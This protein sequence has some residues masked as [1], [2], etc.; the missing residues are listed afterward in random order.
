M[1]DSTT[2]TTK[3][4][5]E[6]LS[7]LQQMTSQILDSVKQALENLG[8]P[9]ILQNN[10]HHFGT[11]FQ[12][13]DA[14][15]HA[16]PNGPDS[17]LPNTALIVAAALHDIGKP[18]TVTVNPK[19]GY[20]QYL[21][22]AAKSAEII[23]TNEEKLLP[24]FDSDGREYIE[25]LVRLHDTKYAKQGKCQTMLDSHPDGF[26]TDLI[27]LQYADIMGQSEFN[28]DKKLAEVLKFSKFIQ[29][30]GTPEQT[31]GLND[32]NKIIQ[33]AMDNFLEQ[34]KAGEESLDEDS[35]LV[36]SRAAIKDGRQQAEADIVR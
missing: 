6:N 1:T 5:T 21:G 23:K 12:H 27:T 13:T 30:V 25:E 24:E 18:S 22:H 26:A 33:E 29:S 34:Q 16:L 19:T 2:F 10:P 3:Q 11:L 9:D 17:P 15:I 4:A 8:L 28:R 35:S 20:D 7:S 14:V 32:V 36:E 31:K